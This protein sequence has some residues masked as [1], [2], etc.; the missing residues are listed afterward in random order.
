MKELFINDKS[1]KFYMLLENTLKN[2]F[3]YRPSKNWLVALMTAILQNGR[4]NVFN[5]SP[6]IIPLP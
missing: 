2:V 4:P 5:V 1:M 6:H 3:S